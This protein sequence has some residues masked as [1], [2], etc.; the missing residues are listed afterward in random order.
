M[1]R[2]GRSGDEE[3]ERREEDKEEKKERETGLGEK[4]AGKV[5]M[6]QTWVPEFDP[7]KPHEDGTF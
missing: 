1:G 5:F 6:S 3:R 7:W 2:R 4:T